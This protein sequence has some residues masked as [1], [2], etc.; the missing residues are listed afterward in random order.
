MFKYNNFNLTEDQ[1][2]ALVFVR[3]TG[4]ITNH[5]FRNIAGID[6]LSASEGLR[7]ARR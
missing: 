1:M 7:T 3:E 5:T 4:S 2:M 6:T